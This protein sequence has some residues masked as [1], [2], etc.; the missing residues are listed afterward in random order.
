M[1]DFSRQ[2]VIWGKAGQE[3]L[4]STNLVV[5]GAENLGR[6][7]VKSAAILGIGEVG[8]GKI[9]VASN[10]RATAADMFLDLPFEE[11]SLVVRSLPS[12]ISRLNPTTSIIPFHGDPTV[13]YL[14]HLGTI[15]GI[16]STV[17][18]PRIQE[19]VLEYASSKKIPLFLLSTDLCKGTLSPG[20]DRIAG[21]DGSIQGTI[22]SNIFAGVTLEECRKQLFLKN[23]RKFKDT[24]VMLRDGTIQEYFK[25]IGDDIRLDRAF[26]YSINGDRMGQGSEWMLGEGDLSGKKIMI[27]GGG[28]IGNYVADILARFFPSRLDVVDFDVYE[29]HN[30]NRQPLAYGQIGRK[31]SEV[32]AERIRTISRGKTASQA[33]FA[34][35]EE[36]SSSKEAYRSIGR[37]WLELHPYDLLVGCFD[38]FDVRKFVHECALTLQTPYADL[39]SSPQGGRVN[40]YVPGKTRCLDCSY[41]IHQVYANDVILRTKHEAA[42]ARVVAGNPSGIDHLHCRDVEGSVNMSNQIVA[43]L[44]AGEMR[45]VFSSD[46]GNIC[47]FLKYRGESGM[48]IQW[49][50]DTKPCSCSGRKS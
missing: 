27:L 16:I 41:G 20:I 28:A 38:R 31:K 4:A 23:Q 39:G 33:F 49:E 10:Y 1:V 43:G 7:I 50:P 3:V 34:K 26:T 9:H 22:V 48:K 42:R 25:V 15:D 40:L 12:M 19:L 14:S 35:I 5:L 13:H 47:D 24:R 30:L 29:E 44:F 45:K 6:E 36:S 17:N 2:E 32:L 21:Y 37:S 11:G 46:Y 18:D 8:K